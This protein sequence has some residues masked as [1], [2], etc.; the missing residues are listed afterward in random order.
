MN[1]L[2]HIQQTQIG[3]ESVNS[4]NIKDLVEAVGVLTHPSQWF[5]RQVSKYGFIENEDY[6]I[7]KSEKQTSSGIKHILDYIVTVDTAKELAMLVNNERGRK[8][9]KYFIS[10]EKQATKPMTQI[11]IVAQ[12]AVALAEQE[13]KLI[14]IQSDVE[15][16]K[17]YIDEDIKTRPISYQQQKA[18]QDE[19][20][21]VVYSLGGSDDALIKK[22]HSRIW[23]IFKKK[24]Y[25][26]RYAALPA[27][28]FEDGLEFIR[29]LTIADM[30]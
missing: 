20:M 11:E 24:F 14:T 16:V 7:L 8:V 18:L 15:D 6:L 29:N 5:Q 23:S 28:K 10:I 22:L 26:P 2:I 9:R 4:V 17:T 21:R 25:L 12:T 3:T 27:V 30:V 19:K 13:K 1:D